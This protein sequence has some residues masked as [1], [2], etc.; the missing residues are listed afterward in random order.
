MKLAITGTPGTG[1][2]TAA[3][4]LEPDVVHLNEVIRERGLYTETD[5]TRD[6]RVVDFDQT[7]A[8]LAEREPTIVESHLAHHFEA[9]RVVVLR[10]H[11]EKLRR[12][13]RERGESEASAE[14]N[15]EAEALDVILVEALDRHADVYEIDTTDQDPSAVATEINRVLADERKPSAGNVDFTDYL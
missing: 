1:K 8:W 7:E 15:A 9:E 12:R 6:S 5:D 2:T 4:L 11:P 10:C 13:L 3:Q 14:E